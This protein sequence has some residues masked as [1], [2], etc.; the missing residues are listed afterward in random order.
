MDII[1]LNIDST[2]TTTPIH[3]KYM[4]DSSGNRIKRY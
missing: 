4:K 3:F 2:Q 1:T